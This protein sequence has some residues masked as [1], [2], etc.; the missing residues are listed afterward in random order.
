MPAALRGIPVQGQMHR[1][2]SVF[3]GA[4]GVEIGIRRVE[5]LPLLE[6]LVEA[7]GYRDRR[8]AL[9]VLDQAGRNVVIAAG[10]PQSDPACI[11]PKILS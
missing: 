11:G 5:N 7:N 10:A 2:R 3:N 4:H 9:L 6:D 1:I 8:V